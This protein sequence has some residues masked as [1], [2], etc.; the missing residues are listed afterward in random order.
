[1]FR[2]DI[3]EPTVIKTDNRYLIELAGVK[4]G[5]RY[6]PADPLPKGQGIFS[7]ESGYAQVAGHPSTKVK[8]YATLATGVLEGLNVLDV[9]TAD[10]VV[11]QIS[12]VYP[13]GDAVPSVTFLGTR[14]ENL[15]ISG[16]KVEIEL[17]LDIFG[18]K[19]VDDGS[20]FDDSGVIS[21]ISQQYDSINGVPN[22][23]SWASKQFN[24]SPAVVQ[25]G[26]KMNCALV[27]RVSGSPGTC[28][29]H[30]IDLPDF[31]RI[32][33]GEIGLKRTPDLKYPGYYS[34][35]FSLEMIRLELG[36][37][38]DGS[39]TIIALDTNGSGGHNGPNQGPSEPTEPTEPTQG[40][41]RVG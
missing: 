20:Y 32:F 13:E 36:C 30:V 6:V 1:V 2:A 37:L 19:P 28:F 21:R 4:P 23:P 5:Y 29:G 38:A 39:S 14:F 35:M 40:P 10:R 25:N 8:G 16:R 33:L 17:N 11:G 22:L 41:T 26:N 7:F 18:S 3:T 12:T 15:R 31:G 24:W 34:Y 9:L 27:N